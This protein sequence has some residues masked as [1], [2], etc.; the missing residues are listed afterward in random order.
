MAGG[1]DGGRES[2]SALSCRKGRKMAVLFIS[3]SGAPRLFRNDVSEVFELRHYAAVM[4]LAP[5]PRPPSF[6]GRAYATTTNAFIS[7]KKIRIIFDFSLFRPVYF[8]FYIYG[9]VVFGPPRPGASRV[10]HRRRR[11][12]HNARLPPAAESSSSS[13]DGKIYRKKKTITAVH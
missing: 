8:P 9:A 1:R 13:T 4:R 2:A 11:Y 3:V 7:A 6:R 10:F 5:P 12:R